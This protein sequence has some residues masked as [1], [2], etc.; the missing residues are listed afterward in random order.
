EIFE[1]EGEDGY[2]AREA[3]ALRDALAPEGVIALGGGALARRENLEAVLLAGT[4]V[5]LDAPDARLLARIGGP[6]SRPLLA[7][8]PRATL[9]RLRKERAAQYARAQVHI[10]T[11]GLSPEE[12]AARIEERL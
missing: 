9:A 11:A 3:T 5:W 8:D 10:D 1:R 4:L 2:R 7:E 12:V 6:A